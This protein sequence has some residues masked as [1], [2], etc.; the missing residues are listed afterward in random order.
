MTRLRLIGWVIGLVLALGAIA[1][2]DAH[3]AWAAIAVLSVVLVLR[4]LARRRADRDADDTTT[5]EPSQER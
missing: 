1:R 2:N 5:D 4:L 3:L